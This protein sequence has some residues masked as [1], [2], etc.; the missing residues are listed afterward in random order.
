ME[1]GGRHREEALAEAGR[2]VGGELHARHGAVRGEA[3]HIERQ[4]SGVALVTE[5]CAKPSLRVIRS[6]GGLVIV[7]VRG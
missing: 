4:A 2:S 7:W 3:V 5:V 6:G 1:R